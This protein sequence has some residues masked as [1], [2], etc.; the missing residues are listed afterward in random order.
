MQAVRQC[1]RMLA[2]SGAGRFAFDATD[3]YTMLR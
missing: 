2:V 1:R 3:G